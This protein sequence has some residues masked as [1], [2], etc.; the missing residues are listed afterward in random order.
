M[1]NR[2]IVLAI[3]LCLVTGACHK[4]SYDKQQIGQE[5]TVTVRNICY[6]VDGMTFHA[7]L[8]GEG[9]WNLFMDNL[10]LMARQGH[11]VTFYN[12]DYSNGVALSKEKV[13]FTTTNG[14]EAHDWCSMM[15]RQGYIVTIE[16]DE[17]TGTYTCIAIK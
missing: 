11:R 2:F 17:E 7:T 6:T 8:N 14:D 1:R 4:E 10:L 3:A 12:E 5:E 16:Y 13:T 9:E 15:E